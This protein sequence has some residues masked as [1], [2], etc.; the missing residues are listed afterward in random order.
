MSKPAATSPFHAGERTIQTRAGVAARADLLGRRVIR[1]HL[2]GQHREFFATLP[3]VFLAAVDQRGRPW[4]SPVFGRPG[5]VT[6]PTARRLH[7]QAPLLAGDP[8]NDA[9]RRGAN[10]GVLGIDYASRRRNRVS[11]RVRAVAA[12]LE[13]DVVQTFGNCPQYIQARA[14]TRLPANDASR[15]QHM[16]V[17]IAA[18]SDRDRELITRSDSFMIASHH[19]GPA[20][21]PSA[22]AGTQLS[23]G[24]LP[25]SGRH[26]RPTS[27]VTNHMPCAGPQ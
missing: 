8:L 22:G 2:T 12:G 10:V 14:A 24:S 21:S 13:L 1:D 7:V 5:F 17:T 15:A 26:A 4:A 23:Y 3:F 20:D 25:G 9:L 6:T 16:A 19:A 18:L 27:Q 11:A